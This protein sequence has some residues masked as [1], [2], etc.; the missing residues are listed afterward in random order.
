MKL[1]DEDIIEKLIT[2][3]SSK[4][5]IDSRWIHA[6]IS[7]E[8]SWNMH[9]I[10]YEPNYPYLY[11]TERC[12]RASNSTLSTE[13]AAQKMS[14]GLCQIMGALAREQGFKGMMP[15]L[16]IPE[17]NLYQLGMRLD[18]LKRLN[19]DQDYVFAA[20]NAGPAVHRVN[21]VFPNQFYVDKI[22]GFLKEL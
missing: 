9:A 3:V 5:N 7:Q 20:Y 8:S 12:A 1:N 16:T 11:E 18:H 15:E 22:N 13:I 19:D 4:W 21:G 2:P 6:I 17:V 10:K 14:W